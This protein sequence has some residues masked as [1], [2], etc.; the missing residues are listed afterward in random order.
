MLGPSRWHY[1]GF[2][3]EIDVSP[4]HREKTLSSHSRQQ[5]ER[6]EVAPGFLDTLQR[7][8][9]LQ[10]LLVSEPPT[11]RRLLERGDFSRRIVRSA[12]GERQ[13]RPQEGSALVAG[14]VPL[15]ALGCFGSIDLD[16]HP[17]RPR[18]LG[19]PLPPLYARYDRRS[20]L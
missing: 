1:P 15:P 12:T 5:G 14:P 9:K 3:V 4:S 17:R 8:A 16:L 10:R 18:Y 7:L 6:K 11:A 2:S 20:S 13:H 19:G